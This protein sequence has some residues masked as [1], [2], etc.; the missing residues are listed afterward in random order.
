MS[1]F[2]TV[3]Q[4]NLL[5]EADA[6]FIVNASNTKLLLG[7][8][9]SMAFKRHCGIKLQS[10]MNKKVQEMMSQ[11]Q[12]IRQA[13]AILTS[14]VDAT[15][16]KYA[17]HVAIMDYTNR[18][19]I[20]PSI[21]TIHESLKNIELY[22]KWY[23]SI[24]SKMKLVLPLMGCGVGGL[25][26]LQVIQLYKIFFGRD[27]DFECEVVV[28]GYSDEDYALIKSVVKLELHRITPL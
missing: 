24:S 22:L 3:K 21:Q 5:E 16:F 9:V 6:T 2:I 7:S 4:G 28:Y 25:D 14:S 18:Q 23:S 26:K 15:N 27:V 17:I 13:D 12:E 8:G 20:N 19:N 11:G 10:E 1:Y